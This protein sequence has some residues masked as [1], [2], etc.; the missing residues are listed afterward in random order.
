MRIKYGSSNHSP[1]KFFEGE[2]MHFYVLKLVKFFLKNYL[3]FLYI[4]DTSCKNMII[5]VSMPQLRTVAFGAK[6]TL[7]H[8]LITITFS[9]KIYTSK[10]KK[11]V[12]CM[13]GKAFNNIWLTWSLLEAYLFIIEISSHSHI[14]RKQPQIIFLQY[15]CSLTMINIVIEY[16]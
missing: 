16:L 1:L 6:E 5:F 8:G 2:W 10:I 11:F 15:R 3:F 7:Q 9:L 12:I 4:S 13:N 14:K